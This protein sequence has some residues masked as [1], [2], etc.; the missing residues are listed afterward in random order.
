M[1]AACL[2]MR[3]IRNRL[4]RNWR[5]GSAI[6][7]SSEGV[8]WTRLSGDAG[9]RPADP[10]GLDAM[11]EELSDV[12]VPCLTGR[13]RRREDFYWALVIISWVQDERTE[14]ARIN[15]FVGWERRLKL[16]WAKQGRT[17]F[18]GVEGAGKQAKAPGAPRTTY[19][20]ILKN[21]AVQGM[22]GAHLRPLRSLGLV[23]NEILA[24]T[25]L[26]KNFFLRLPEQP[27]LVSGN[28]PAWEKGFKVAGAAFNKEFEARLRK[29]LA[30]CMP[31]LNR[32]LAKLNWP[33]KESW[34]TA[35]SYLGPSLLPYARLAGEFCDWAGHVRALFDQLIK[36]RAKIERPPELPNRL[37]MPIPGTL[38]RWQVLK[39]SLRQW[40]VSRAESVL[41][42]L[43]ARVF[44]DR[45]YEDELWLRFED[46]KFRSYPQ[47]ASSSVAVGNGDCRWSNA[48]QV[49]GPR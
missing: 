37:S 49:M 15:G 16:C 34:E 19:A 22:L 31:D 1:L 39:P 27:E 20:P 26:G 9:G 5:M 45:G 42:A 12:L 24:L 6:M 13:T 43:H 40:K 4:G 7:P 36:D 29:Q 18:G 30:V 25:D 14:E 41:C 21:Q 48:V 35:S 11:R 17:G 2:Q 46:G 32:A 28:W 23:E 3:V 44:E 38:K 10:L 8:F 33:I 47:R